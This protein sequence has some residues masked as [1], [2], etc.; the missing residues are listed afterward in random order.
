[1]MV[2]PASGGATPLITN[3]EAKRKLQIKKKTDKK[4]NRRLAAL[5]SK[6][7]VLNNETTLEVNLASL[8]S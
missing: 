4:F 3:E 7:E 1:M 8:T 5:F 6:L 2:D